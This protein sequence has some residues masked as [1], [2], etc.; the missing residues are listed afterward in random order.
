MPGA[1]ERSMN[2]MGSKADRNDSTRRAPVIGLVGGIG[3]GKSTVAAAWRQAGCCVSDSDQLAKTALEDPAVRESLIARWG[4]S[5]VGADN[6]LD[7][8]AIARIVFANADERRFLESLVHPWI[9]RA[10][11]A[12]FASAP[13]TT[14]AFVIDAPLLLEAGLDSECDAVVFVDAPHSARIDRVTRN[15]GW[16]PGELEQRESTQWP[17]ERKRKA[18]THVIVNDG[19]VHELATRAAE[20]LRSILASRR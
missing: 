5:I 9:H 17:L 7:R 13:A 2:G 10:R 14:P 20:L 8:A 16:S 11:H 15:R 18:A 6:K 1:A 3:S 19:D 4:K 12:S